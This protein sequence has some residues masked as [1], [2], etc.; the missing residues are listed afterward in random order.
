MFLSSD[1]VTGFR[2]Q[3]PEDLPQYTEVE[4]IVIP[5]PAQT[6]TTGVG[7]LGYLGTWHEFT[8]S[9]SSHKVDT[10]ERQENAIASR[11]FG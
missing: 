10:L 6:T 5:I 7:V 2:K 9:G 3:L 11:S 4:S 8:R 1:I